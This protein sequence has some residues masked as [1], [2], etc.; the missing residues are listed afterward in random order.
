MATSAS[1]D[2]TV[3]ALISSGRPDPA[4]TLPETAARAAIAIWDA[5]VP[6]APASPAPP[7][8]GYRGCTLADTRG[9]RWTAHLGIITLA[10]PAPP[11]C[12]QDPQRRFERLLVE[13]APPGLLPEDLL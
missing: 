2:W 3:T 10:P 13:S 9:R 8:L 12:R 5:A 6:L 11:E 7:R 4:W 1:S